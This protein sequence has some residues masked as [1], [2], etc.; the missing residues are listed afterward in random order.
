M[1]KRTLTF[2]CTDNS[3]QYLATIIKHYA[4]AAFPVGGS[5]CAQATRES[6][7]DMAYG[8]DSTMEISVA[9]NRRQVPMLKSAIKWYFSEVKRDETLK[10][11][12]LQQLQRPTKNSNA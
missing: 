8:L 4:H 10:Q 7:V 5:E 9:I 1:K 3:C 2:S 11:H 6:L 12:L